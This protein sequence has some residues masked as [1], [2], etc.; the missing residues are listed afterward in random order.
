M[1]SQQNSDTLQ[2]FRQVYMHIVQNVET[3][4]SEATDSTVLARVSDEIDEYR[5]LFLQ[6]CAAKLCT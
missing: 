5:A 2:A 1:D 4:L 6:V 3:V